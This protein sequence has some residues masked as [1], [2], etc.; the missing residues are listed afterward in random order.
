ML[1]GLLDPHK[2][3][4]LPAVD[5]SSMLA[6]TRL[7]RTEASADDA[8]RS[9]EF[10]DPVL[11]VAGGCGGPVFGAGQDLPDRK[12]DRLTGKQ[13]DFAPVWASFHACATSPQGHPD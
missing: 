8:R 12:T 4:L 3:R 1:P 5:G 7:I 6:L 2:R 13:T 11:Y 10:V 9:L